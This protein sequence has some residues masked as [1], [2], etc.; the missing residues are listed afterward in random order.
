MPIRVKSLM[1]EKKVNEKSFEMI[2]LPYCTNACSRNSN[3]P[4]LNNTNFGII[5]KSLHRK[6]YLSKFKYLEKRKKL[7]RLPM[8]IAA[9]LL[10]TSSEQLVFLSTAKKSQWG[11]VEF[12]FLFLSSSIFCKYLLSLADF[13]AVWRVCI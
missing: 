7:Y 11:I 2:L 4:S 12:E 1:R 3:G 10:R 9:K 8:Q 6:I 5:I 13:S